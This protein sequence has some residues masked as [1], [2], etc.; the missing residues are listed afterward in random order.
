M[1]ALIPEAERATGRTIVTITYTKEGAAT[2][3]K[4]LITFM[5]SSKAAPAI[6]ASGMEPATSS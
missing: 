3:A 4:A 2:L 6:K 1:E 5:T